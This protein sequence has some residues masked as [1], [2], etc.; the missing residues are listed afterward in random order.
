MRDFPVY[1]PN[2]VD[3]LAGFLDLNK[4]RRSLR[5]RR[6]SCKFLPSPK[7]WRQNQP[8]LVTTFKPP[9]GAWL[10]VAAVSL[11]NIGSPAIISAFTNSGERLPKI[12]FCLAFA[13]ASRRA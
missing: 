8:S 5:S 3:D 1:S 4:C 9:I 6:R 10:H 2:A 12:A 7:A 11:S 13:G